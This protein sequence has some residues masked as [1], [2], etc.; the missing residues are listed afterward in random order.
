MSLR[1]AIVAV[2]TGAAIP[3]LVILGTLTVGDLYA[4]EYWARVATT[5][6]TGMSSSLVTVLIMVRRSEGID[7]LE[8]R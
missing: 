4:S 2:V 7:D 3:A 1:R 5:V 8:V 6:I